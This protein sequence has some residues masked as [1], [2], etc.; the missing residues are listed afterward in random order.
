M[1]S[2]RSIRAGVLAIVA[3]TA[4]AC[5]V[6]S[7]RPDRACAVEGVAPTVVPVVVHAV[8]RYHAR[9]T[10]RDIVAIANDRLA[11]AAI[12]LRVAGTKVHADLP[13]TYTGQPLDAWVVP[14]TV[15][16]FIFLAVEGETDDGPAEVQGRYLG[17]GTIVVSGSMGTWD[18]LA[19]EVGHML[20]LGHETDANNVMGADRIWR[21]S[22]TAD[23]GDT[24]RR[25]LV[26]LERAD[27]DS[28][29][30]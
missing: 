3:G 13:P 22:F 15:D 21:T 29:A 18:T 17:D 23:Q 1:R 6:S 7:V 26:A 9:V 8:S 11:D 12:E 5:T 14:N 19:H 2:V 27:F 4:G 10:A 16:V 20:G 30:R 28:V 25:R 24:M